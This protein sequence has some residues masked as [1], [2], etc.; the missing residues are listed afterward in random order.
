M[1][2]KGEKA[3]A[4]VPFDYSDMSDD[5]PTISFLR[6][7]FNFNDAQMA[8]LR[9]RLRTEMAARG[10]MG[11][12]SLDSKKW[13]DPYTGF[14]PNLIKD[15]RKELDDVPE[16]APG[17][18][19]DYAIRCIIHIE[20]SEASQ[21]TAA[22]SKRKRSLTPMREKTEDDDEPRKKLFSLSLEPSTLIMILTY[23]QDTPERPFEFEYHEICTRVVAKADNAGFI[24]ADYVKYREIIATE[25]LLKAETDEVWGYFPAQLK[26]EPI[27]SE[28]SFR[29]SLILQYK[30]DP[31][32]SLRFEIRKALNGM[33]YLLLRFR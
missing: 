16:E 3:V 20:C 23:R 10:M 14:V 2:K 25:R 19:L 7:G 1:P 29:S 32:S 9:T 30:H 4:K 26:W 28:F 22:S 24:R 17:T 8:E 27:F 15:I 5:Q 21:S 6:A 18:W 12:E 33:L 13:V 31:Q 11:F